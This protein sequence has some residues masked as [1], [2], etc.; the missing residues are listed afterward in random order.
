[1]RKTFLPLIL[2]LFLSCDSSED[3]FTVLNDFVSQYGF[4]AHRNPSKLF[5]VGTIITGTPLNLGIQ[6]NARNC[7]PPEYVLRERDHTNFNRKFQHIFQGGLEFLGIGASRSHAVNVEIE[8]IIIESIPSTAITEWYRWEMNPICREYANYSTGLISESFIV[9]SLTIS[10][11]D[12]NAISVALPQDVIADLLAPNARIDW[13]MADQYTLEITTPVNLG[14]RLV[15]FRE[16]DDGFISFRV[17]ETQD[18]KF[19]FIDGL[20]SQGE[21]PINQNIEQ[22]NR[23]MDR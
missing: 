5:S 15:K 20:D 22:A 14:Y 3:A 18:N 9:E 19:V 7:F 2:S 23:A 8:G 6:G 13:H 4:I 11:L 21:S 1:M 10:I 16:Q 17:T 12:E